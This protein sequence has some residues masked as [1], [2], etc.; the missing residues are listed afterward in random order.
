[1]KNPGHGYARKGVKP[2]LLE[3][4]IGK[5]LSHVTWLETIPLSQGSRVVCYE[6]CHWLVHEVYI[7]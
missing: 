5:L 3:C 6:N 7:Q 4:Y 1:M 2:Q